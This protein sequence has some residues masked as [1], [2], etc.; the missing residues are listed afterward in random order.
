MGKAERTKQFILETA[1]PI[2]N[3]KGIA[4][5]SIDNILDAAK[6]AKGCLYGHF[7]SKKDLSYAV[8]DYALTDLKDKLHTVVNKP[9]S[10]KLKLFAYLDFY[11]NP[12][13][14]YLAGGCPM[15]NFGMEADDTDQG[16]KNRVKESMLRSQQLIAGIIEDGKSTGEFQADWDSEEFAIKMFSL[17]EGSIVVSR[18][19]GNKKQM[20]QMIKLL[21]EEIEGKVI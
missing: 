4:G 1:A 16:I 2:F 18:V 21:K 14:S 20:L 5:V 15:I 13:K 17:I 19:L 10:P 12:V 3:Q 9:Q 8:V 7:D 11:A 6:V